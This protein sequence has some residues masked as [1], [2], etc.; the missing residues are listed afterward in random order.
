MRCRAA[1]QEYPFILI[2]NSRLDTY[3]MGRGRRFAM[4]ESQAGNPNAEL[5]IVIS[6]SIVFVFYH[7]RTSQFILS[8]LS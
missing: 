7:L 5:E 8:R 2:L 1:G 3:I 4:F 6:L